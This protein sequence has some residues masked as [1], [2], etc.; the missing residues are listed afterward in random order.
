MKHL[1]PL[2]AVAAAALLAACGGGGNGNAGF[3]IGT[4][5]AAR[6]RHAQGTARRPSTTLTAGADRRP[7][8]ARTA[9]R[10]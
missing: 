7:A 9:C 4:G 2:S 10:P 8:N 3:D 6:H 1:H 5:T